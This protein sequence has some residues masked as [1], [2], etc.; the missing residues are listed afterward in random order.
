LIEA[1]AD[2]FIREDSKMNNEPLYSMYKH[3][4]TQ[5]HGISTADSDIKK[6]KTVMDPLLQGISKLKQ[7]DFESVE[8]AGII[9]IEEKRN[10]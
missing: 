7:L 2:S 5:I 6:V 9:Q 8:T 1:Q 4:I 10:V 3:I